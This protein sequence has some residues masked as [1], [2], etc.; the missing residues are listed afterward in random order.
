MGIGYR[1][2]RYL[3]AFSYPSGNGELGIK[4]YA[5]AV[6]LSGQNGTDRAFR[7]QT[8]TSTIS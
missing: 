3:D 7:L 2:G 4:G 6:G 1:I 5:D 8:T